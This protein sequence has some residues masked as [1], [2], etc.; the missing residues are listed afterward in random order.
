MLG[1][2][3]STLKGLSLGLIGSLIHILD[4]YHYNRNGDYISVINRNNL[5][6]LSVIKE[7]LD[8]AIHTFNN[9]ILN[10]FILIPCTYVVL[11]VFMFINYP[12]TFQFKKIFWTILLQSLGAKF[13]IKEIDRNNTYM[14]KYKYTM[15]KSLINKDMYQ[16]FKE[17]MMDTRMCLLANPFIFCF[18][19]PLILST[20]LFQL[21]EKSFITASSIIFIINPPL[22]NIIFNNVITHRKFPYCKAKDEL[23]DV[24]MPTRP[25]N[26][27]QTFKDR[28]VNGW[29]IDE[30]IDYETEDET[31]DE[32]YNN[33]KR[34]NDEL[35]YDER[36][37]DELIYDERCNDELI[38]DKQTSVNLSNYESF[39][40]EQSNDE[41]SND[42]QSN[43]E[44]SNDEEDNDES[45]N[46]EQN[47]DEESND[48]QTNDEQNNDKESNEEQTNIDTSDS[49]AEIDTYVDSKVIEAVARD[50]LLQ[51][52]DPLPEDLLSGEYMIIES[53]MSIKKI[54]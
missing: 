26:E 1:I 29:N 42:E 38:Y 35:I 4:I 13:I 30:I 18:Y 21:T 54:S 31:D 33:N 10:C 28:Y 32:Q 15:C 47:N 16:V 5:L 46:D 51:D 14:F 20:I 22:A 45:S 11:D 17:T 19:T 24:E 52:Y 40:T 27:H 2:L 37:N 49:Y 23:N 39:N 25:Q 34:C 53:D 7:N 36:C 8:N 41:Q 9:V 44:Q 50:L 3:F 43:D 12:N 48:E 6:Q